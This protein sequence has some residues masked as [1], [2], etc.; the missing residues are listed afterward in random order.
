MKL[1][2]ATFI[3][4]SGSAFAQTLDPNSVVVTVNGEKVYASEYYTRMAYLEGVGTVNDGKFSPAPPAFL[5][6][7]R[8]VNEKLI[9]QIAKEKGV[10]PTPAEIAEEVAAQKSANSEHFQRLKDLGV[11]DAAIENQ[12]AMDLTQFKL[13]TMGIT[14]TDDQVMNHYNL[15]K[16]VYMKPAMVKMRVIVV[17]KAED[18]AKVES[19]LKTKKFGD[20][21]RE[22]STDLTKFDNGDLPNVA[23]QNLPQNVLNE[24]TRTEAGQTT[25]WIES[26]GA[27]LKYLVESKSAS[28]PIP[29]DANL[30]KAIKRRMMLIAGQQKNNIGALLDAKKRDGK[31]EINAPGLQKLWN[32]YIADTVGV[33]RP[34]K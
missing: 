6:I 34:D 29:L 4:L 8:L 33:K 3:A 7:Q 23:I 10:A 5:T 17:S 30:K 25:Q 28:T 13:V 26:E 11:T 1:I 19:A 18:K 12:I 16:M 20:V 9:M 24:V 22:M 32:L 2:A 21:A 15:N 14:I 31:I 27:Y